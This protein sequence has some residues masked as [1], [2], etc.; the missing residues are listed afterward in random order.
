MNRFDTTGIIDPSRQL[1]LLGPSVAFMQ[2]ALK[3]IVSCFSWALGS[4]SYD[5]T[6]PIAIQGV[7]N[8]GT[9]TYFT[10]WI[11]W[12]N[13]LFAF[14]GRNISTFANPG[15]FQIQDNATAPMDPY[16][17]TDGT[18]ASPHRTRTIDIV[19]LPNGTAGTFNLSALRFVQAPAWTTATLLNSWGGTLRYRKIG[20]DTVEVDANITAGTN[21]ILFTSPFVMPSGFR[22]KVLGKNLPCSFKQA[23]LTRIPYIVSIDTAGNVTLQTFGS[24]INTTYAI[25]F[26]FRFATS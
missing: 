15:V 25:D 14:A 24:E 12:S 8:T 10:G 9:G 20:T 11:Y 13:E 2:D 16:N 3:N 5:G 6:S 22:P 4:D 21:V 1:P 26:S 23:G 17:Y 18:S 19:D 7:T